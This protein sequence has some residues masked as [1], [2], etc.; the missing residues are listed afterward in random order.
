MVMMPAARTARTKLVL[1]SHRVRLD[2]AATWGRYVTSGVVNRESGQMS[3]A[4][5]NA[6]IAWATSQEIRPFISQ[7]IMLSDR[8]GCL[9]GS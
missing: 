7:P 4:A 6:V 9:A 8:R 3:V 2:R 1:T 5:S